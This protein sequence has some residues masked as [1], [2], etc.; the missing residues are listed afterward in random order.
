ME[1]QILNRA[2]DWAQNSYF[3][4][5]DREEIKNLLDKGESMS[6]ELT[7]RFYRDLEFGTGGLRAP[8]GMGQNRMNKYNV[9]RASQAMA[10]IIKKQYQDSSSVALSYDSRHNSKFFAQEAAGVFAANGIKAYL[11][12]ELSPTPMLSFGVRYFKAKAGV[13]VTASHNPPIYNGFKAFWTD[14]AQ[15][16]PP[17]DK[18]IINA[19]NDLTN[20]NDVK[21]MNFDEGIKQGLIAWAGSD[22]VEA[23]FK[24]IE[25][26]VILKPEMIKTNGEKLSVVYTSLH[27][28][29]LHPCT[30]IMN[31]LGFKNFNIVEEQASFD[32]SFPTVK[33]PN[34]EDPKAMAMAIEKMKAIKADV[35]YGTDPDGDRLGVVVN[36]NN[37]AVIIN[38][39][40]I[41]LLM[42]YYVL[43]TRTELNNLPKKPLVIKSIVTSPLQD[44]IVNSFGGTIMS[45]LTGFKWMCDLIR[46][47]ELANS[48]YEFVFASEESF[49]YMPHKESRD[50]DGVSSMALMSEVALY[51]KL[52]GK[53]LIDALAEIYEKFGF[54]LESLISQDYEGMAGSEKINRIME[55]FRNY[56]EKHFAGEEIIM[57]ED[58][59]SGESMDLKTG[60]KTKIDLPSS[61]V[62]SFTLSSGNKFFL[63]P[64]GTEPKIKFYTMVRETSGSLKEKE[65][66]A[67]KKITLI[68]N[69]IKEIC[70]KA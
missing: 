14:G 5:N 16:T 50:K 38:G 22:V 59:K 65:I 55:T 48:D 58:Y 45:T 35:V 4:Q 37:E 30:K 70:E 62:L 32:G 21:F 42:I 67:D 9:R 15:V 69:K 23:F 34:P 68:E 54:A 56:P 60:T 17:T 28:S 20:W 64:S 66:N 18:E 41:G 26:N 36:H 63:R 39:N 33:S 25:T 6:Q 1:Q 7:E 49:G 57:K 53:T 40:Q 8:M 31:R 46:R 11:F 27:G 29:A 3:D 61:N 2:A 52:Q 51:Y 12:D 43:K 19:Y 13:M 47:L 24:V 10:N 44:V